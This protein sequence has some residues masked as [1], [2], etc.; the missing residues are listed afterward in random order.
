M[1]EPIKGPP[2]EFAGPSTGHS[3]ENGDSW[4]T[5]IRKINDGFK[6]IIDRI[7]NGV[8]DIVGKADK[9]A[10]DR[11]S[12]LE[13]HV[14]ALD[15]RISALEE[16]FTQDTPVQITDE[17]AAEPE[18]PAPKPIRPTGVAHAARV[19]SNPEFGGGSK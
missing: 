11:V 9:D 17:R 5:A 6:S 19:P 14:A 18:Q 15:E 16:R 7:E 13:A 10:R 8:S 4:Y 3:T 2:N 12:E 1:F